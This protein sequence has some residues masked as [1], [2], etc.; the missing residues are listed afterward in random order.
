MSSSFCQDHDLPEEMVSAIWDDH[1]RL[2]RCAHEN[3]AHTS[4]PEFLLV[5]AVRRCRRSR[6]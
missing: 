1:L 4:P 5:A 2:R 3:G 6:G